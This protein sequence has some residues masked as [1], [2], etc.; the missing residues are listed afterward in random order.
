MVLA[1]YNYM[2]RLPKTFRPWVDARVTME[3]SW[4]PLP[5][6]FALTKVKLFAWYFRRKA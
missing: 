6:E 3:H 2:D 5:G 1:P 4:G